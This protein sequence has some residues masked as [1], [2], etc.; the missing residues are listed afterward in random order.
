MSKATL[1]DVIIIGAG[2]S[3]LALAQFLISQNQ[4]VLI[5]EKSRSVG[6]RLATRRDGDVSYDHGAQFYKIKKD[7]MNEYD[8]LWSSLGI[9]KTW[10]SEGET[11]FK[12]AS[13]G[14]TS[15]AK[16]LAKNTEI[17]FNEKV[18]ELTLTSGE[19]LLQS[20]SKQTYSASKIV[21]S[22]PLPQSLDLLRASTINYPSE[23]SEIQY[24]KALVGLFE[25]EEGSSS[26]WAE[27]KYQQNCSEHIF[28]ISNQMSKGIS[29]KLA[30]TVTMQPAWSEKYFE[31]AEE[32]SLG[33]LTEQFAI[34]CQQ[35]GLKPQVT[36][37]QLKK[38]RYSHPNQ[39]FA[40]AFLQLPEAPQVF[41]MGDAFGGGSIRG[42][43]RSAQ[44]LSPFLL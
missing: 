40:E 41:L 16:A 20:E 37:S 35:Q 9:S 6:G 13:Q 42:A 12:V 3:G 15:L 43:L 21:L 34:F 24:A 22:A 39:I 36:K 8:Q 28:S 31:E 4:K 14:M 5:L 32:K 33:A 30:F 27:F 23:L 18:I 1:Y 19:V 44:S 17:V 25:I 7:E 11:L 38:W 10:F 2:I 26:K 29:P